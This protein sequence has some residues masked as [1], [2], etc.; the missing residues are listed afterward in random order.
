MND[1]GGKYYCTSI[2][3]IVKDTNMKLLENNMETH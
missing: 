2:F 1:L 3:E